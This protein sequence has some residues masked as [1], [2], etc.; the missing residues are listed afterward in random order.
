M[1]HSL[2]PSTELTAV[3]KVID[4][5][6]VDIYTADKEAARL[7]DNGR[8]FAGVKA[9]VF[10]AAL[11]SHSYSSGIHHVRIRVDK[12]S[13]FLGIRSRS[14]PLVLC[15]GSAGRHCDSPSAYGWS[16][17]NA[18]VRNGIFHAEVENRRP[19]GD[20]YTL[21]LDCDQRRLGLVNENT[22][23]QYEIEVDIH[24]T[25]FPWCLLSE[26]SNSD[27]TTT[28]TTTVNMSNRVGP[29][30]SVEVN[31]NTTRLQRLYAQFRKQKLLWIVF[32]VICIDVVISV[33]TITVLMNKSERE[34]TS[35]MDIATPTSSSI[36]SLTTTSSSSSSST[37][38]STTTSEQLIPSG[39]IDKN[40][41]WKKNAITVAGGHEAGSELNQLNE[42]WGIHVDNDDHSIYIADRNNHR[43]VRWEFGAKNGTVVAGGNGPGNEMDQLTQPTDVVLDKEKK[44]LIICDYKNRRV[45]RWSLQNSQDHQVLI[46]GILCYGLAMDSNGDLYISDYEAQQVI[47]WQQ[48]NQKSNTVAGGNGDG[49]QFNQ[50]DEPRYIFVDKDH[51]VYIADYMNNRVMKWIKNATE[52]SLIA[53]GQVFNEN[54]NTMVRPKGVIVDHEGN[55]Y[56]SSD[57]NHQITL[58]SPGAIQG[59]PV[60]GE[61]Q[62]GHEPTQ[63]QDP[64]DLSFDQQGNLYVVDRNNHRIQKF[65]IDRD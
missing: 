54:P 20:I 48:G 35:T 49:D 34:K 12:G 41:K 31:S 38:T 22:N 13:P 10:V 53:P 15:E 45:I 50:L 24:H 64:H 29:D 57:G 62:S 44:Y 4:E 42:P 23:E 46:P 36:P 5:K 28:T 56:M 33:V 11:G 19:G 30:E 17:T 60:I 59:T 6:F 58:W 25:P 51:S 7:L 43:I 61:K 1:A 47:R 27:K 8:T 9:R 18:T 65:A 37:T 52:G 55:I 26:Y 21:T 40:T 39:I 16:V 14:I 63:F 3:N 2:P 32:L